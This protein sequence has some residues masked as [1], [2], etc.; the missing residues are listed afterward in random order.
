MHRRTHVRAV[1]AALALVTALAV[2]P[3]APANALPVKDAPGTP[4]VAAMWTSGDK[5]GLGTSATTASTVWYTLGDGTATDVFYPTADRSQVQDLQF[6]VSDGV[7]YTS[8]ERDDTDH[9]VVLVDDHSLE[10]RQIDTAKDG[11]YRITKTYITDPDRS[12]VLV[13]SRFEQ[14]LGVTPLQLYVLFNPSIGGDGNHNTGSVSGS[15][16]LASGG[17]FAS[18]LSSSLP[19]SRVSNGYSGTASDG[20]TQL[21]AAHTLTDLYDTASTS[22]NIVQTAEVPVG[23]DTSFTLALGFGTSTAGALS[24]AAASSSA[25]FANREALFNG[26][27]HAR[28]APLPLPSSVSSDP[29]LTTQ[30]DVALMGLEAHEDKLHPGAFVASLSTPWG[31]SRPGDTSVSGYHSVWPRD[32]YEIA[33]ALLAAGDRA[34]AGRALD[35]MLNS[36]ERADGTLPHNSHVDGKD[37]ELG[38]LQLDEVADPAILAA[39][40]GR[41]DAAT[42]AKIKLSADYVV[43]HGPWTPQ[44]RWE[45]QAG[46]SPATIASEIAGLVSAAGIASANGDTGAANTYLDTADLWQASVESWTVTHTGKIATPHYERIDPSGAPDSGA[47]VCDTNGAGCSDAR[48]LVDPSF[49]ELV[50]LGIKPADDP[51]IAAS[52]GVVDARLKVD[53]P[54][55]PMWHR[56]DLDGYGEHADGSPFDGKAGGK[57]GP[58]PVLSGERGEYELA[59]GRDAVPYLTAMAKSANA[60]YMIAEQVWDRTATARFTPGQPTDSAAPLAWAMAQYVRLAQSISAGHNLETPAAVSARYS[61]AVEA[62]FSVNAPT[63]WGDSVYV[64]GDIPALGAWDPNEAIRLSSATYPDWAARVSLPAGAAIQYKFIKKAADGTVTWESGD[65]R[66]ATLPAAGDVSYGGSWR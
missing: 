6:V 15:I 29:L 13:S 66:L 10:Y 24:A 58:W 5:V 46:F 4:G 48:E 65:N 62:T 31:Q 21:R 50:R 32:L 28:L 3:G 44:E 63:S 41:T 55:G 47:N 8:V 34:A 53:T 30:Y 23:R 27:W 22:G 59:N 43:A 18:A 35:F 12:T 36:Q 61:G 20:Y 9:Q 60:G 42:W 33:T 54:A 19:F 56:Y 7:A 64:V 25:G 37:T 26:G 11:S 52:V 40:L 14:L 49:L 2:V 57:G 17:G 38:G 45:E 1:G 16:L 51:V 39:Q